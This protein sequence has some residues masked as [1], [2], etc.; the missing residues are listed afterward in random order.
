MIHKT[1]S[2]SLS[3]S[4]SLALSTRPFDISFQHDKERK[5]GKKLRYN[6]K[7]IVVN[8]VLSSF[9][10][11]RIFFFCVRAWISKLVC[12]CL[13]W[14]DDGCCSC[15]LFLFTLVHNDC[16]FYRL[17]P[18]SR[19]Q[20]FDLSLR[21]SSS[22][23]LSTK[24]QKKQRLMANS[25]FLIKTFVLCFACP[26]WNVDFCKTNDANDDNDDKKIGGDD[27]NQTDGI[28]QTT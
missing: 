23:S 22:M 2:L 13:R 10:Q 15:C 1:C 25:V 28:E 6:H 24:R 26:L 21:R 7:W 5:T 4:L 20:I 27:K 9:Y 17:L 14:C 19:N 18:N 3:L 16:S 11:L 8:R 12:E